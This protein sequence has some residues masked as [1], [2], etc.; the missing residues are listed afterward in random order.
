MRHLTK[1][2]VKNLLV[3][4]QKDFPQHFPTNGQIPLPWDCGL[5]RDIR[6]FYQKTMPSQEVS[7]TIIKKALKRWLKKNIHA[8][9]KG[10]A[11]HQ[12]RYNLAGKP[13]GIVAANRVKGALNFL[14]TQN[15]I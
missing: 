12:I 1:A 8:Y 9:F 15:K 13:V 6:T 14:A 4:L 5:W 7:G 3:L 10:L 11:T 2:R